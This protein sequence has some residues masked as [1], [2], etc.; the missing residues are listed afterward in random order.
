MQSCEVEEN[1]CGTLMR[2]LARARYWTCTAACV[3]ALSPNLGCADSFDHRVTKDTGGIYSLQDAVP[4]TLAVAAAGCAIWQ[5]SEDRFGKT[6][7]EA[8]E[9]ALSSAILAEGLQF[10]TARQ[11]PSMT[12]DPNHWFAG[13]KGSFPSTHVSV[14]TAVVTPF[15]Y[16][17]IH[18]QPAIAALAVLPLYEMVARVKAQQHWQTDVL[19]GLALGAAIGSYE[20]HRGNP[21]VFSLLPGGAYIGFRH[22]F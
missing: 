16:E 22:S 2:C 13:G 18:D 17:Y 8:G 10:I 6:C 5:G 7:W 12:S 4:V 21:L 1:F 15:I 11:A 20:G 3:L 14:T 19:A 9:S